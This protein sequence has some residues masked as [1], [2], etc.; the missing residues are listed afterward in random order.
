MKKNSREEDIK[1]IEKYISFTSKRE[2]FSH[3]TDWNWNKDL[4]NK[5][6][7]ILSDY[8]R[9]L[10]ENEEVKRLHIQDNKHLDFIIEHSIPVQ[11]VKDKIEEEIKYHE[12][13]ILDIENITMLKGKTAKEEAEIEF[14]KYAIVVLKKMLQELLEGRK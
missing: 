2:N 7:H 12:K 6:E 9:V 3:D 11:K 14:N 5:I 10:K 13:N 4:A 8:K 1:D